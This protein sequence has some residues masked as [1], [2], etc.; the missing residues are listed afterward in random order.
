MTKTF[1]FYYDPAHGWV[2]VP[3]KLLK[4][5]NIHAEISGFSYWNGD[6]A[7]LEEDCDAFLFHNRIKE[8]QIEPKYIS[9]HTNRSSKIRNY[10]SYSA[11]E[12]YGVELLK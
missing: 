10:R 2:K 3:I 6:Y 7:Y 4:E 12:I 8:T 5:L 11:R 9:H 1:H